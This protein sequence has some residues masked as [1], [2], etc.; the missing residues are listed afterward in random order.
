[1]V[2]LAESISKPN[3]DDIVGAASKSGLKPEI[4]REKKHPK[5][6]HHSSGR[7]LVPKKGSKSDILKMIARN[8]KGKRTV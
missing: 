5:S 2:P 6:W 7:I 1:M 3:I 4:E 8:L